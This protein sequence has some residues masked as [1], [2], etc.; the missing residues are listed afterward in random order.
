MKLVRVG[1][2]GAERPGLVGVGQ[3]DPEV[4]LLGPQ[5]ETAEQLGADE[6]SPPAEHRGDPYAGPLPDRVVQAL[7][8]PGAALG[9]RPAG[10][11]SATHAAEAT[12][13]GHTWV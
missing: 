2:V 7:G 5:G 11:P 4:V 9:Q 13:Y 6:I 12:G 10:S 3:M 1:A 8:Q